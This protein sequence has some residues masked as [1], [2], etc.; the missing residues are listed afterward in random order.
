MHMGENL[1]P[2]ENSPVYL[3]FNFLDS[4]SKA[5]RLCSDS[6]TMARNEGAKAV[7]ARF[8]KEYLSQACHSKEGEDRTASKPHSYAAYGCLWVVF[9][10]ICH[11]CLTL[12]HL[13]LSQKRLKTGIC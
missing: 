5:E 13:L 3:R 7:A 6:R 2:T 4:L 1:L 9:A 11:G 10:M 12:Q 8:L